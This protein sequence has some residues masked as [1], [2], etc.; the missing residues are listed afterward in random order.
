VPRKVKGLGLRATMRRIIGA[1]GSSRPY[2][3][4]NSR[5]NGISTAIALHYMDFAPLVMAAHLRLSGNLNGLR[6]ACQKD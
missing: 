3:N 6:Q 5:R 2:S 1:T 4:E